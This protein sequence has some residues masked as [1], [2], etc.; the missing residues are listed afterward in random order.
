MKYGG[1]SSILPEPLEL[2]NNDTSIGESGLSEGLN[3]IK[4]MAPE[5][6]YL[7]IQLL[8]LFFLPTQMWYKFRSLF[9]ANHFR[10]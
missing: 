9:F 7:H 10:C 2:R 5:L 1:S 4:T 6:R 3:S 8:L